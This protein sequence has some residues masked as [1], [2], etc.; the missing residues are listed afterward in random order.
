MPLPLRLLAFLSLV[1]LLLL[2]AASAETVLADG[3][4]LRIWRTEDGLPQNLVTS[5]VQTQ[6]GYLWF[7]T[8][9]GLARFNGERFQVFDSANT[10]QIQDRRVSRL[11]EDATGS[12]WI[13]QEAG[14]VARLRDGDFE[15][16][17]SPSG[18]GVEKIIGLGS[19]AQG[20]VWAMHESGTLS[21]LSADLT[22]PSM[23]VGEPPGIMNWSRSADGRIYV[24]ENNLSWRL[25]DSR[26]VPLDLPTP[27]YNNYVSGIAAANE[28][29]VWVLCDGRIRRLENGQWVEDRGVDPWPPATVSQFL[30]LRDGTLAVGTIAAG[31]YLV[32]G[33][34]RPAARFDSSNGLPQDW[35]R[36]LYEDREGTL[37]MGSGSAGLV[38]IH[39]S[40][41][42]TLESPDQWQGCSTLALAAG[43]GNSLW[44]GTDG[45]GLYH[46]AAGS[47]THYGPEDGFG[48]GNPYISAVTETASGE[49]WV[50]NYW[51]G[52][53][54]RLENGRFVRPSGV[55]ETTSPV[56]GLLAPPGADGVLV[57]NREGLAIVK[58]SVL[59]WLIPS[60]GGTAD[61]VCAI[62]QDRDGAI[63]C[64]F[65]HGGLARLADGRVTLFRREDG[66]G[67]NSIQCL[68][69]DNDGV[70]WIG[71]ADNGLTRFKDGRFINLGPQHGLVDK[72]VCHMLEDDRG[73]FWISTHRGIQRVARAELNRC[74][75]GTIQAFSGQVYDRGDGLPVA[76]FLG[77]RQGAGCR[78]EDGR[79]WF[80]SS[81]GPV[82]VDPARIQSN[83]LPPP[84]VLESLVVDGRAV[85]VSDGIVSITL[86]PDHERLEFRFSALSY[87][88]PDKVRFKYRLEGFDK[89]WVEAG[90][91][92]F[93]PYS[94][95][96][97][98]DYRFRVIGCNNDGVWN[99]AGAALAFTIAPFFWQTWWFLGLCGLGA[100]GA[101]AGVARFVT[102]K[103]MQRQ[104]ERME[105]QHE[106]E[107][108]RAR[109]AQDIHDDVG[110]SLS[111]IAM[112][113]QPARGDLTE[114]G[115]TAAMLSNI[116]STAREVTRSLDEIVWAVDPR[117]DTLDSLVD[118]MCRYAQSFLTPAGL[119]CRLD[120]PV[121]VP[122]W[123]L[124]AEIRHHLFL[125]FKETLNNIS[126]H[127][128]ATEVRVSFE[129]RASG[130]FA[131]AV[132]DNGRG[133]ETS[134]AASAQPDRIAAGN[135][136]PNLTARLARIGGQVEIESQTGKGTRVTF[137]IGGL[138]SESS[139]Q[140]PS[141][142]APRNDP[143]SSSS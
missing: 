112:L 137:V 20:R 27:R 133:F 72:V 2:P 116:Y 101:V 6:D 134:D 129:L 118:Y 139:R 32:F 63:W 67:S 30:E 44:I 86:P 43:A 23:I 10:P 40:A 65:S 51:W 141:F 48:V 55:P 16:M 142:V 131:L 138:G 78:T 5:A 45:A 17:L 140:A 107:R 21:C 26:L 14:G 41:F 95:L 130:A 31:L 49:V 128:A 80:A 35:V 104:I 96:P 59:T 66:I 82:A 91:N 127:A 100:A 64:G 70:L 117:H 84:V 103:R 97:A 11:F 143:P 111:R 83:P 3:Y 38:S 110:A 120:V 28:G 135:G 52:G 60:P 19:D 7:G 12:L 34:G 81:E 62:A 123:P 105:R 102:R 121:E 76:E 113:S 13:G 57:G 73:F 24:T 47:W 61:D 42:S 88:A 108:E 68:F 58:D 1:I 106:I 71:T 37:W 25:E 124:T 22:I 9:S 89:D 29:G 115:R 90:D 132:K 4:A 18:I 114:P 69:V 15:T 77:G 74:A 136:L 33:D 75:D 53:P 56:L 94:R 98:G 39:P 109:I 92:R 126:K 54:Y 36:F 93:A 85:P 87:V 119:R 125:A 122:P 8:S 79:L 46:H 50:G 99:T